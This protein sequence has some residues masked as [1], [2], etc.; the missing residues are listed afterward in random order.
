MKM[1]WHLAAVALLLVV[2]ADYAAACYDCCY[3]GGCDQ[4][5]PFEITTC[6]G[7]GKGCVGR[8][9]GHTTWAACTLTIVDVVDDKETETPDVN[10]AAALGAPNS[11]ESSSV[12]ALA[13]FGIVAAALAVITTVFIVR[14]HVHRSTNDAEPLICVEDSA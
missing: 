5:D 14:S 8:A 4:H 11:K 7:C 9:Q 3:N 2:V 6:T 12:S 13:I 10:R 1:M